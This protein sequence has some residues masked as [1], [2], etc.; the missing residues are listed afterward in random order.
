MGSGPKLEDLLRLAIL[1]RDRG[2]C[3]YC[4]AVV[5]MVDLEVDHVIARKYG[6]RDTPDNLV[7]ACT[8]C[9]QDKAHMHLGTYLVH[10]KAT[11]Q[12]TRGIRARV[13][14]ALARPVDWSQA[15]AL[16][17]VATAAKRRAT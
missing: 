17:A 2:R 7:A 5:Q 8:T 13:Q 14:A 4:G 3:V 6:G 16:L 11:G 12:P 9:N 15:A 10:R 1:L